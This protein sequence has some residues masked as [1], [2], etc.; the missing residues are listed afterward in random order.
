MVRKVVVDG[1]HKTACVNV[2][3][4]RI[5]KMKPPLKKKVR[6]T[7]STGKQNPSHSLKRNR[8]DKEGKVY[9]LGN[10]SVSFQRMC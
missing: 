8:F 2:F 4:L 5:E 1:L 10:A 7:P 6:V 3:S 9:P